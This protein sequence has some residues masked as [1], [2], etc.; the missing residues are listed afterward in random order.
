MRIE[1]TLIAKKTFEQTFI[2][3]MFLDLVDIA[4]ANELNTLIVEIARS[5]RL[6]F[7]FDIE[8]CPRRETDEF[9]TQNAL[10]LIEKFLRQ[11]ENENDFKT[12]IIEHFYHI[13]KPFEIIFNIE[14]DKLEKS[15]RNFCGDIIFCLVEK[16]LLSLEI[17]NHHNKKE[18][19]KI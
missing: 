5:G 7:D 13:G 19:L 1:E 8:H 9:F 2:K 11:Y 14:L 10:I 4:K 17:H 6:C 16:E 18:K 3:N 12:V 15:A